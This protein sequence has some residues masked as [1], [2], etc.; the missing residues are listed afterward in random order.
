MERLI[1]ILNQLLHV[2]GVVGGSS[3]KLPELVRPWVLACFREPFAWPVPH[4]GDFPPSSL[5]LQVVVGSQSSGKSSVLEN[6]VGRDFLPRGNNMVTRRPLV[7]QLLNT[8]S[9]SGAAGVAAGASAGAGRPGEAE[10]KG[11]VSID[12]K[13]QMPALPVPRPHGQPLPAAG[14]APSPMTQSHSQQQLQQGAVVEWGEFSH[15]PGRQFTKFADIKAEINQ[16][17]DRGAGSGNTV[18]PDPIYL[19]I[20]SPSFLNLTLVDLPGITKVAT[21]DQP[22]DIELQI[23]KMILDRISNPHSIIVAVS[24]ANEDIVNSEALKIA[25]EVDPTFSRTVGVLTKLDLMDQG[26]D[27]MKIFQVSQV[28]SRQ[29]FVVMTRWCILQLA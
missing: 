10:R 29:R 18:S 21:R 6:I 28:I 19:K 1:P 22:V 4:S 24:A 9:A 8:G 23:R 25:K 13:R 16:E 15:L 14:A 27:A 20:Y 11:S 26:T 2:H 7:L 17:T 3:I 12:G 5:L